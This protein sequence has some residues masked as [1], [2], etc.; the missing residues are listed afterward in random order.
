MR[1]PSGCWMKNELWRWE[2]V[3]EAGTPRWWWSRLC[4]FEGT[5]TRGKS[6]DGLDPPVDHGM[7]SI[8]WVRGVKGGGKN[9][10]WR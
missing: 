9:S 1:L 4:R 5:W 8:R 10:C 6:G 2:G 3:G 7:D